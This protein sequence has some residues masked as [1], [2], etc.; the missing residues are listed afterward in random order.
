MKAKDLIKILEQNP[1]LE[2]VIASS[3]FELN[4]SLVPVSGI[5]EYNTSKKEVRTFRD[6]FDG[7]TYEKEIYNIFDG[8][9]KILL[10]DG[11]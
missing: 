5:Y 8:D 11:H 6:A 10:I 7:D 2:V 9:E 3:N 1:E 4:G